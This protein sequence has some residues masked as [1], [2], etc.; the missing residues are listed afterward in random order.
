MLSECIRMEW[1]FFTLLAMIFMLL[2]WYLQ[3]VLLSPSS[4]EILIVRSSQNTPVGTYV[5]EVMTL[6][7]GLE[8]RWDL[9]TIVSS[10]YCRKCTVFRSYPKQ[11]LV[12]DLF[13]QFCKGIMYVYTVC[14]S[15][16]LVRFHRPVLFRR[17]VDA[18]SCLMKSRSG[19]RS[20]CIRLLV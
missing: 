14:L 20:A 3:P 2:A 10:I 18:A 8:L 12:M 5:S 11:P 9:R 15:T 6:F 4:V 1:F 7:W 19:G 13:L 17:I 16:F